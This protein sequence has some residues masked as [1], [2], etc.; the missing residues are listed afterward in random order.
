ME[1]N[2]EIASETRQQKRTL[3]LVLTLNVLLAM[4]L[5]VGGVFADSSGLI[6]NALDNA[7]DAAVYG[8]SLFAIGRAPAWKSG[9]AAISGVLLIV[10][11]FG[12]LADTARRYFEGS[13]PIGPAMIGF[14]IVAAIINLICLRLLTKLRSN[15][16][17]VAAARTFSFND[18]VSNG[19]I[20]VSGVLV[21]WLGQR[22]P[23]LVAGL[24][25]GVAIL[26]DAWKVR[27]RA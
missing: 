9:A 24:A 26:R 6:A 22:W 17:N 11:A 1:S 27:K 14:A 20:L 15:D 21:L 19:G 7:S 4:A 8:I 23:D 13:H 2:H 16:V 25:G 3:A 10:F 18:F 12:V 5:A